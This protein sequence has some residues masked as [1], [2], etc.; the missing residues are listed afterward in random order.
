MRTPYDHEDYADYGQFGV[1]PPLIPEECKFCLFCEYHDS[2]APPRRVLTSWGDE[3]LCRPC[4]AV[5]GRLVEEETCAAAC[6]HFLPGRAALS[7]ARAAALCRPD[8][9]PEG[10]GGYGDYPV[11]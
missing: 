9:G 11:Q 3:I 8:P 6:K 4:L 5:A 2:Q 7:A 10:N 1:E